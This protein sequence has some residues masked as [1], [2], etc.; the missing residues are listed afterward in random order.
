MPGSHPLLPILLRA[1]PFN[2]RSENGFT[3]PTAGGK[4]SSLGHGEERWPEFRLIFYHRQ[5]IWAYTAHGF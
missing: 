4:R 2:L 5:H 3:H 1:F